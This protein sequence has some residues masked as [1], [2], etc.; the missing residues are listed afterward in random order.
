[1]RARAQAA[2]Y[3]PG[4]SIYLKDTR[5][6]CEKCI[7]NCSPRHEPL[8]TST[9]PSYPWQKVALDVADLKGKQILVLVD[10]YSRYIEACPLNNLSSAALITAC[11]EVFS[12]HGIPEVIRCDNAR[13]LISREF[14]EFLSNWSIKQ[15][16]SS[17]MYP[18]SSGQA[19]SAVKIIKRL[20]SQ[21]EDPY[22]ALLAYRNTPLIELGASPVQLSMSRHIRSTIPQCQKNLQPNVVPPK[23]VHRRDES[24]KLK[25]KNYYDKRH[26]T[27]PF[28]ALHPGDIVWIMDKACKGQVIR[29]A[30]APRSY[31]IQGK[32]GLLRRNRIHLK[33]LLRDS[34]EQE[35][36]NHNTPYIQIP[37]GQMPHRSGDQAPQEQIPQADIQPQQEVENPPPEVSVPPPPQV[38]ATPRRVTRSGREVK[39]PARFNI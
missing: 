24:R 37:V 6:K 33:L 31:V 34:S 30:A 13:P 19:E 7:K 36:K 23:V 3:W 29:H 15:I 1:M 10:C 26:G 11:K 32:Y 21:A 17:P 39:K 9:T 8:I 35:N 38:T 28:G 22:L 5:D 20:F 25:Q 16:T 27:V 14:K 12:R 4:L 2:V 18:Q